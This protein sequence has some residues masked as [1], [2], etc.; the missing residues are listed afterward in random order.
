MEHYLPIEIEDITTKRH[1]SGIVDRSRD[2]SKGLLWS[3]ILDQEA[4]S[5]EGLD[6]FVGFGIF[7]PLY[8]ILAYKSSYGYE[9]HHGS[10]TSW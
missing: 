10:F 2:T 9:I 7:K 6:V 8:R 1:P 3:T 4:Q 5:Y